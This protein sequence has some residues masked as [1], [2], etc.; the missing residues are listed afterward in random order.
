MSSNLENNAPLQNINQ[1]IDYIKIVKILWSRWYWV[2]SSLIICLVFAYLYLWYT[3]PTYSTTATL[4]LDNNTNQANT[5]LKNT[6]ALVGGDG[7][8]IETESFVIKSNPIL[9]EAISKLDYRVAY[10]IKGR[11]RTK[12]LYPFRPFQVQI[13]TE[14]SLNRYQGIID[15]N[16]ISSQKFSYGYFQGEQHIY[17]EGNFGSVI[18]V[19]GYRLII[20]DSIGMDHADYCFYLHQKEDYLN[21]VSKGLSIK[22]LTKGSNILSLTQVDENPVFAR[23]II[24]GI[25]EAYI[26][27][28]SQSQKQSATQTIDFIDQQ[29]RNMSGDLTQAQNK[30]KQFKEGNRII[31]IGDYTSNKTKQYSSLQN[32]LLDSKIQNINLDLLEEQVKQ[33]KKKIYLNFNIEG[34]ISSL[35]RSLIEKLN[36][37]IIDRSSKLITYK[38]DAQPIKEIDRQIEDIREAILRNIQSL[39]EK[40]DREISLIKSELTETDQSIAAI[41][42]KQQSFID[43]QRN[44]DLNDK[45][46]SLFT[47]KKLDAEITRSAITPSVSIVNKASLSRNVIA[48]QAGRVYTSAI[49]IGLIISLLVI[50]L[51]RIINPYIYDKET[52]ESYTD[53]PIIGV[54]KKFP[55]K[56]DKSNKQVLSLEKPKSVFAESIRSVRT[57]L[58]FLASQKKSKVICITSEIAGE[59]KSFMTINLASTLALIDKKVVIVAA[60]LRKSK[61]HKAFEVD[62]DKGLSTYLA[63]QHEIEDVLLE[64]HVDNLAFVPSGPNPPNPSELIQSER[65]QTLIDYLSAHYDFVLID[66]APL[67]LVSDSVPLI[68]NS[69]INLFVIRSGVS[70]IGSATVPAKVSRE[71]NLNNVVIVLNAFE[72]DSLYA[73]YYTTNYSNSYYNSYYYYADYSGYY[74]YGYYDDEK[75]SW[76]KLISRIKYQLKSR[77]GSD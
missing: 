12:E 4:K 28:D 15:F 72:N 45:I 64:T 47:E 77:K 42:G 31:D 38:D 44:Y 9:L 11:F 67:G 48:P 46:Y 51:V 2:A 49:L 6:N 56:L 68:R 18:S 59:G 52:V 21:R 60:D 63:N 70:R 76:W 14:D 66:T 13:L 23:D 34:E 33:N 30:L 75:P 39:R 43:L 74:G 55:T 65:M 32:Q 3:P 69:D 24:N 41:P 17:K 71:Y 26:N 37:L 10:F 25:M 7:K 62:N 53:L 50:V 36:T 40:Q 16:K 58:S 35:L 57:N 29:L 1:E 20:R 27:Y 8:S 54:V 61:M 5:L 73:R 22:E 19:P